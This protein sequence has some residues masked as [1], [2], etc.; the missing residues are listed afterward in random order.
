MKNLASVLL[1]LCV[2]FGGLYFVSEIIIASYQ[3]A[4]LTGATLSLYITAVIGLFFLERV[5]HFSFCLCHDCKEE[6]A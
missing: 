6:K 2:W 1:A 3:H 4:E 5:T